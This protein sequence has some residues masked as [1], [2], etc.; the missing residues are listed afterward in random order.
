M[1]DRQLYFYVLYCTTTLPGM[2]LVT[3][4][5]YIQYLRCWKDVCG[6][7]MAGRNY[8]NGYARCMESQVHFVKSQ[9]QQEQNTVFTTAAFTQPSERQAFA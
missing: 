9:L 5:L 1:G 6:I 7:S 4:S 2:T 3:E 8:M